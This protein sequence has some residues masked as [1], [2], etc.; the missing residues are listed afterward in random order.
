MQVRMPIL[1]ALGKRPRHLGDGQLAGA[2][3]CMTCM[4]ILR[5][6]LSAPDLPHPIPSRM[7]AITAWIRCF[8]ICAFISSEG[9]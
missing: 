8:A 2:T 7:S 5:L 6:Q 9:L 4:A 3:P 1:P